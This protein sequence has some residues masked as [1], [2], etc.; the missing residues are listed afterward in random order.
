MNICLNT[1]LNLP[2]PKLAQKRA[3]PGDTIY[4]NWARGNAVSKVIIT[5]DTMYF[6]T[7]KMAQAILEGIISE[8]IPAKL[9]RLPISD[10]G[11]II[12]SF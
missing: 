8:G 6:S 1:I 3:D 12:K 10:V 11:D 9:Y 7:E 5:Y 4:Y 2:R